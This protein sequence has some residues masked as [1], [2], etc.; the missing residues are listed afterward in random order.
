MKRISTLPLKRILCITA[1]AVV[2]IAPQTAKAETF[3]APDGNY[4]QLWASCS[5]TYGIWVSSLSSTPY[6]SYF[7]MAM[8]EQF[9]NGYTTPFRDLFGW[10]PIAA[11]QQQYAPVSNTNSRFVQLYVEVAIWNG[12]EYVITNPGLMRF[13]SNGQ[14]WC[15]T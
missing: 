3:F 13:S 6:T 10:T 4:V 9:R 12:R 5:P 8:R 7:R 15:W 1:I 14:F 11:Y 2:A